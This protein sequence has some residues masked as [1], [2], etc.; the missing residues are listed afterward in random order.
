MNSSVLFKKSYQDI[1]IGASV[2]QGHFLP[3]NCLFLKWRHLH[4]TGTWMGRPPTAPMQSNTIIFETSLRH[5]W[6]VWGTPKSLLTIPTAHKWFKKNQNFFFKLH[7]QG[8]TVT[9]YGPHPNPT[10]FIKLPPI[11]VSTHKNKEQEADNYEC[12][13]ESCRC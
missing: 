12:E 2:P 9:A 4:N 10:N 11:F 1:C 3:Q 8:Q 7:A 13:S 6:D 5:P